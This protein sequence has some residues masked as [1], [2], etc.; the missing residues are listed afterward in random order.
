MPAWALYTVWNILFRSSYGW[1]ALATN[2]HC[3]HCPSQQFAQD[4]VVSTLPSSPY[5]VW[6][7]S[8]LWTRFF[9]LLFPDMSRNLPVINK[10]LFQL[11]SFDVQVDGFLHLFAKLL[12]RF[13][14][15]L[16]TL[17]LHSMVVYD[18]LLEKMLYF[19][20]LSLFFKLS[21]WHNLKF[22]VVKLRP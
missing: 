14:G 12:P 11:W 8:N 9:K 4:L 1:V 17:R 18:K 13:Q 2:H 22:Q 16:I 20:F 21:S 6:N 7:A 19:Y 3:W 15:D 10:I 5:K